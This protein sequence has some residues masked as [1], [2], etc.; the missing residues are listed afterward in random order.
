MRSDAHSYHSI[1]SP[2]ASHIGRA[3]FRPKVPNIARSMNKCI[4]E[5]VCECWMMGDG[6]SAW[7]TLEFSDFM[8]QHIVWCIQM[9][10]KSARHTHAQTRK[11]RM[12]HVA[13]KR[14]FNAWHH[15]AFADIYYELFRSLSLW[16][17]WCTIH[18]SK[19]WVMS[20]AEN[21]CCCRCNTGR[22]L[23]IERAHIHLFSS[24]P[25]IK[26]GYDHQKGSSS[27]H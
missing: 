17:L 16:L 3:E 23:I 10:A 18:T 1:N 24:K 19:A 26:Y 25:T 13:F 6:V 5:H 22:T 21:L 14:L 2:N 9:Y 11:A 4:N 15:C 12:Q 20:T 27:L 7:E 8:F